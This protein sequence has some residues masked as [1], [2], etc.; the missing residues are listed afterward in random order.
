MDET[1]LNE[2]IKVLVNAYQYH[3]RDAMNRALCDRTKGGD[4]VPF[5][6]LPQGVYLCPDCGRAVEL[7]T[8]GW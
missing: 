3:W 8:E 2:K 5:Y 6:E 4:I 7:M 1:D